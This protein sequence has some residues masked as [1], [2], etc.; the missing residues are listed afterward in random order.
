MSSKPLEMKNMR[1]NLK[2]LEKKMYF[3]RIL[4][5]WHGKIGFGEE[6]KGRKNYVISD[7]KG[8]FW[9]F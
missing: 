2:D 5:L 3:L 6:E 7:L 4:C 9:G 8:I 1:R